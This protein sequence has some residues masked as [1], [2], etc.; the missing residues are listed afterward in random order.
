MQ[1]INLDI[2]TES[3]QIQFGKKSIFWKIYSLLRSILYICSSKKITRIIQRS[4]LFIL[5][6]DTLIDDWKEFYHDTDV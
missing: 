4:L 3:Y 1:S 2:F 5:S 6:T